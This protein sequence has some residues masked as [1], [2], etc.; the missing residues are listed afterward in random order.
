MTLA[1][2][3]QSFGELLSLVAAIH[4]VACDPVWPIY[5]NGSSPEEEEPSK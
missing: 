4:P 3:K 2:R 5:L 1:T